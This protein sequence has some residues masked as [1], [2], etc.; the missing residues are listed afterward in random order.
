MAFGVGGSYV[1]AESAAIRCVTPDRL[2]LQSSGVTGGAQNLVIVGALNLRSGPGRDCGLV[3]SLGF[4]TL[5]STIGPEIAFGR[6][7]WRFVSTPQGDGFVISSALQTPPEQAPA[8]IPVLMYHRIG[9]GEG[10]LFVSRKSLEAQLK[11]LRDQGYATL[12]PADLVAHIDRGLPIPARP[13]IISI[14]DYWE[15]TPDFLRL[16]EKYG[17]RGTYVLPNGAQL[18]EDEIVALARQGE[19]CGHTVT[20]PYL[21]SLTPEEQKWQIAENKDWLEDI[22][23]HSVTCFAYPFGHFNETTIATVQSA[24]YQVAFGANGGQGSLTTLNRWNVPRIEVSGEWTLEDFIA[25]M[26]DVHRRS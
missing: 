11:W 23:G 25:I 19:V 15:P 13:I 21:D 16:L 17:F 10:P 8:L 9:D 26:E 5:V 20:H 22:V 18:S 3:G 1:P 14:D 7:T 2:T 12:T 24:G 6:Q 4:G